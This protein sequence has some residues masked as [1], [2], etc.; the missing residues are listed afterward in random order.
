LTRSVRNLSDAKYL[1]PEGL[2]VYD[3]LNYS[4]LVITKDAIKAV[5]SR[6]LGA[7]EKP[8]PAKAD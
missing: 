7:A 4:A 1:A 5:E 8:E 3:I 2:N 6:I